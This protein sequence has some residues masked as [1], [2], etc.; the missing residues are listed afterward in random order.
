M[1]DIARDYVSI[2]VGTAQATTAQAINLGRAGAAQVR[3]LGSLD[4]ESLRGPLD[5]L[6]ARLSDPDSLPGVGGLLA[7]DVDQL[8]GRLGL[9]RKSDLNHLLHHVQRL[10]RRLG[11]VRG[12]R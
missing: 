9:A 12:E 7:T 5:S 4:R 11:E 3:A 10:E 1:I 6:A 8:I 2:G